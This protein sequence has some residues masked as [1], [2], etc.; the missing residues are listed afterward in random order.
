MRLPIM[1]APTSAAM[2]AVDV[3]DGA[4]GEV[5]RAEGQKTRPA[6]IGVGR[7]GPPQNQ[8]MWAIGK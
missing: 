4:A 6:R 8:T 2:P 3:H 1:S 5:D 7:L